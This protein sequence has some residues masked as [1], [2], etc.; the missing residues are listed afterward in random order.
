MNQQQSS[1]SLAAVVAVNRIL[2]ISVPDPFFPDPKKKKKA[3]WL[4]E[5]NAGVW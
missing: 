4:R 1:I 2:S 5:T 3:V